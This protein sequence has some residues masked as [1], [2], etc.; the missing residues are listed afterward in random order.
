MA[1][2]IVM[3]NG[4]SARIPQGSNNP[5]VIEFDE[6]VTIPVLSVS[7]WDSRGN[8]LKSWKTDDV[9]IDGQRIICPLEENETADFPSG[10][11]TLEIKGV[12]EEGYTV[13]WNQCTVQVMSRCDKNIHLTGDDEP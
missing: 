8:T 3:P 2:L 5:L 12:D 7:L 1:R 4:E 11:Q 13:F 6:P 10:E 9:T